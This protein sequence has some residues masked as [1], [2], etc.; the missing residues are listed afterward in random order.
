M[1]A[2]AAGWR[3]LVGTKDGLARD[4]MRAAGTKWALVSRSDAEGNDRLCD[5]GKLF[6][7]MDGASDKADFEVRGEEQIGETRV[8]RVVSG[9]RTNESS[10]S[11][12]I[13]I[14]EPHNIVRF[15]VRS[16]DKSRDTTFSELNQPRKNF[17]PAKG[18]VKSFR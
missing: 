12:W 3:Q 15:T 9:S 5:F 10:A 4:S 7:S 13:A 6:D 18:D 1:K 16:G 2:N 17:K 8:I 14:E 11:F